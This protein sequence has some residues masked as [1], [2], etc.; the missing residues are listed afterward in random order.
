MNFEKVWLQYCC[1]SEGG[2]VP[3]SC[4]AVGRVPRQFLI[5][6]NR[7]VLHMQN[8]YKLEAECSTET[9]SWKHYRS[10]IQ[11]SLILQNSD[12]LSMP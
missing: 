5:S 4:R 2:S 7:I 8:W 6:Q 12:I 1:H 9:R 10:H 3:K 11:E